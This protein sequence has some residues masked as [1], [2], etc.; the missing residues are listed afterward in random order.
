MQSGLCFSVIIVYLKQGKEKVW[1]PG[2]LFVCLSVFYRKKQAFL[3]PLKQRFF[4]L[5]S[6]LEGSWLQFSKNRTHSIALIHRLQG[7]ERNKRFRE[8][9]HRGL[10]SISL[11]EFRNSNFPPRQMVLFPCPKIPNAFLSLL[12][13]MQTPSGSES[14]RDLPL[15][16]GLTSTPWPCHP[17]HKDLHSCYFSHLPPSTTSWTTLLSP[18]IL[19][20]TVFSLISILCPLSIASKIQTPHANLIILRL[21]HFTSESLSLPEVTV[22]IFFFSLLVYFFFPPLVYEPQEDYTLFLSLMD[23]PHLDHA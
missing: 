6:D 12:A 5:P 1:H 19:P 16:T 23:P 15:L 3:K 14:L 13:K 4:P 20:W 10:L 18:V 8:A 2:N 17:S 7:K 9:H 21:S 22:Y 11:T